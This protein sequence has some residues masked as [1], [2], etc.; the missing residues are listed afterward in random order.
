MLLSA[1]IPI[2]MRHGYQSASPNNRSVFLGTSATLL[3][4]FV[5][6]AFGAGFA[7]SS[8][9]LIFLAFGSHQQMSRSSSSKIPIVPTPATSVYWSN[10]AL[11]LFTLSTAAQGAFD[12]SSSRYWLISAIVSY[13]YPVYL[14]VYLLL[15]KAASHRPLNEHEARQE[16]LNYSAEQISYAFERL[17]SYYRKAGLLSMGFYWFG[18]S[19]LIRGYYFNKEAITVDQYYLLADYGL[20]A[21][22]LVA[23][24]LIERITIRNLNPTHPVT[25][26]AK[27]QLEVDCQRAIAAAP[28]GNPLLERGTWQPV[29][30]GII[31][32]PGLA[33]SL[34]WSGGEEENG[35]QARKAWREAV[36]VSGAKKQ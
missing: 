31:A 25:G 22:Y 13:A 26:K 21:F 29:L 34:W 30:A 3:V 14:A 19:R 23:T 2:L 9:G 27:P 1:L 6:R 18:L 35:W 15:A 4:H 5:G 17:W 11:V 24:V 10:F 32:G 28:A 33:A 7:L 8:L 12:P 36:A 16:L 20:A